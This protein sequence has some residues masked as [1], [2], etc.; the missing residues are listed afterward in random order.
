VALF[1]DYQCPACAS[2]EQAFGPQLEK[3]A[4][5][6]DIQLEYRTMTFLDTNLRNDS[7]TRAANAAACADLVGHYADYHNAVFANQPT[8]EGSGYTDEQLTGA[9]TQQAGITGAELE[10]FRSCYTNKRFSGF[11]TR[12]DQE[13]GR[14]GITGTPS[15]TVNGNTLDF[16]NLTQDPNSLRDE[17]AKVQ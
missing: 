8:G 16:N 6:G 3:L 10:E 15:M 9:F 4:K 2:F 17:I 12:V 14:A 13:A 7:S 11:V 5:D 1:A